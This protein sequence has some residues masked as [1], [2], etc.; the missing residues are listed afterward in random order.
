MLQR[1]AV[2]FSYI[3]AWQYLF[4]ILEYESD[5]SSDASSTTSDSD[6][7]STTSDSP[8]LDSFEDFEPA[9]D[10]L[11]FTNLLHSIMDAIKVY[12][13][14]GVNRL[15]FKIITMLNSNAQGHNVLHRDIKKLSK[16]KCNTTDGIFKY[17]SC[18]IRKES[19]GVL[20]MI[21]YASGC[22]KAKELYDGYFKP[23]HK[24]N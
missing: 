23:S 21:V 9:A 2:H 18:Y 13:K 11:S 24:P 12:C 22:K 17:F 19:P 7:S 10:S 6:A 3:Y 20:G 8:S 5:Q 14:N 15:K 16:S 1:I 4:V